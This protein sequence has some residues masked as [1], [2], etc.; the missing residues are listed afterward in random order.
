MDP[1]D[2]KWRHVEGL[3]LIDHLVSL[4]CVKRR[5]KV[6][7]ENGSKGVRWVQ[8]LQEVVKETCHQILRSPLRSVCKLIGVQLRPDIG[9]I[10]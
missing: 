8:V 4:D 9:R 7:E 10:A 3:K 5:A 1:V 2:E 6:D